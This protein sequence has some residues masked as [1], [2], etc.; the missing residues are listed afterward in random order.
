MEINL[1]G[2]DLSIGSHFD[3]DINGY[4]IPIVVVESADRN[5]GGCAFLGICQLRGK[6][7][8]CLALEREDGKD[9]I[10]ARTDVVKTKMKVF[11]NRRVMPYSGGLAVVAANT[12]EEANE[13]LLEKSPNDVSRYDKYGNE[14]G[15]ECECVHKS[16][17]AYKYDNWE[18]LPGV[19]VECAVPTFLA[20]DGYSE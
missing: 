17:W 16:H 12:P 13:V 4:D 6:N 3:V 7:I 10:Y 20:E 5:C 14:T 19:I 1:T 8:P 15:E 2:K 11:I 18:E 9:V